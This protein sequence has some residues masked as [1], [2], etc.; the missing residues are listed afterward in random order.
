MTRRVHPIA[1]AVLLALCLILVAASLVIGTETVNLGDAWKDWRAGLGVNGSP[2]LSIL[3]HQRLPRTLAA[4]LAGAGLA[5]AGCSFQ[6]LLRNPLA[7]PYTLGIASAGAFGAWMTVVLLDVVSA[8]VMAK[9]NRVLGYGGIS[10]VQ[11]FA[12]TFAAL[13]M[14]IIYALASGRRRMAPSVLLLT[15]VTL[16]MMANA[17]IMLM[18]YFASPDKFI[19]MERWLMGGVDIIGYRPVGSLALFVIPCLIVLAMQGGKYDQLGFSP[20]IAAGRGVNVR[21]LQAVTFL[22]GSL[23]VAIIV[24]EVGPI[25]FVGLIVPHCVR[26]VTGSRHRIL[27]PVS[28]VAGGAFLCFCDIVA[29]KILPGETPIGIIT[30]LIGVPFFLVLMFRRGFTDWET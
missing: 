16:G 14:L 11:V 7:T 26:V 9:V 2:A 17:G 28:I 5:L 30:A 13:D 29:R 4:L 12:F 18:R 10:L 24:S 27:M 25:G 8:P 1:L 19:A 20:E 23:M 22:V 3:F 6:A 21:R 15:G